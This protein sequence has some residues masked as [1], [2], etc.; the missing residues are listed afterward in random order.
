[1][2][3]ILQSSENFLVSEWK[4]SC[5]HAPKSRQWFSSYSLHLISF[6]EDAIIS[7]A[8]VQGGDLASVSV[9]EG[10]VGGA[11]C[12]KS[13]KPT[14]ACVWVSGSPKKSTTSRRRRDKR[15]KC[16]ENRINNRNTKQ[17]DVQVTH[18]GE[19][20]CVRACSDCDASRGAG[21]ARLSSVWG[22]IQ[23]KKPRSKDAKCSFRRRSL[24]PFALLCSHIK[25]SNKIIKWSMRKQRSQHTHSD[26]HHTHTHAFC[27]A[28]AYGGHWSRLR[29]R[30]RSGEYKSIKSLRTR[31]Y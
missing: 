18:I 10:G 11:G 12:R 24:V 14:Y 23:Y 7:T 29:C 1:M 9:W 19:C 15:T 16:G 28:I 4:V 21:I 30:R 22:K 3:Q 31:V 2:A 13:S 20:V 27:A 6:P 26:T 5:K 8:T 25:K 17:N